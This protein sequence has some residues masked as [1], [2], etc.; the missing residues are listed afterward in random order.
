MY[1]PGY[2]YLFI[3]IEFY[4]YNDSVLAFVFFF[5]FCLTFFSNP[6]SDISRKRKYE[7]NISLAI[8]SQQISSK[9]KILRVSKIARPRFKPHS[10][11]LQQKA[12]TLL[13]LNLLSLLIWFDWKIIMLLKF[14]NSRHFFKFQL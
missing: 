12:K 1:G 2:I 5:L 6:R 14:T 7:K 10:R 8:W 9:K 13:Q 4:F 11:H 3:F